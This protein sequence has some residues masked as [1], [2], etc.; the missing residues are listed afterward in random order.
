MYCT[1]IDVAYVIVRGELPEYT[2]DKT[3]SLYMQV[4]W[5]TFTILTPMSQYH[6]KV[7][8]SNCTAAIWKG[9]NVG[10]EGTARQLV[11]EH[12]DTEPV[13]THL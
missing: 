13:E 11:P 8:V 5:F 6:V 7:H 4:E 1:H 12:I 10:V 9:Y 3:F 2:C